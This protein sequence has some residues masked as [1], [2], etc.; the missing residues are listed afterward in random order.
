MTPRRDV[1]LRPSRYLG[2]VGDMLLRR[3]P[4]PTLLWWFGVGTL[5]AALLVVTVT[6]SATAYDVPLLIAFVAGTAQAAALPLI[7]VRPLA[8]TALQFAAV[9]VFSVAIPVGTAPTWPLSI[10]GMITLILHIALIGARSSWR[11]ALATWWASVLL[12]VLLVV[13]DPRGRGLTD[14]EGTLIIYTTDSVLILIASMVIR[15]W[16]SIRRQ[17]ADARRDIAVE[18]S[19]RAVAEERTRIARELHDVVAHSMSVI[20]MQATSASYRLKYVDPEAKEEFER[21]AAGA[22]STMREMR[23]LLAVL[24]DEATDPTLAP[25]PTLNSLEDLAES[26]RRAGVPVH[27]TVT[28]DVEPPETVGAAA[29]RIVQESLSNVI[30][31]A[32]GASCTVVVS[33]DDDTV[34]L[35]VTNQA[36]ESAPMAEPDGTGHGLHGMRERV[37]LLGGSLETGPCETGG[38]RVAARL[39]VRAGSGA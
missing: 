16:T 17:L 26:T 31:H 11:A 32:P 30:R 9:A 10:P 13:L 18:Q 29:Y 14:A 7:L 21:I 35:V 36:S 4:T 8:A 27:L 25:V 19:Q 2:V 3:R 1:T 24:R 23:Q 22:R 37:R 38:Y 33:A 15:H 6:I 20:H 39:P 12:L 34:D 5:A 28:A